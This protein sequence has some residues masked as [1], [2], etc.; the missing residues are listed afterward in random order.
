LKSNDFIKDPSYEHPGHGISARFDLE[1]DSFNL[2]GGIDCKITDSIMIKK[3]TSLVISG[4]TTENNTNLKV[5]KWKDFDNLDIRHVGLPDK[6][7]FNWYTASP[8]N[9]KYNKN[10]DLYE[11]KK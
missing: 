3:L 7:N 5:F 8:Q 4:P 2:S 9:I 6:Y 11:F 1:K 10:S